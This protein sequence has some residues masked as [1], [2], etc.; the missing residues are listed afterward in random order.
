MNRLTIF[1]FCA[2][3]VVAVASHGQDEEELEEEEGHHHPANVAPVPV[4]TKPLGHLGDTV[5]SIHRAPI[6]TFI[7]GPFGP[8]NWYKK[9]PKCGQ[10]LQSPV[11]I[12][13]SKVIQSHLKPLYFHNTNAPL[14]N[15]IV[16]NLFRFGYVDTCDIQP[17]ATIS[18][19]P[20]PGKTQYYFHGLYFVVGKNRTHGSV[21][22]IVNKRAPFEIGFVFHANQHANLVNHDNGSEV[23]LHFMGKIVPEDNPNFLPITNALKQV[24]KGGQEARANLVSLQSLF[25]PK[26]TFEKKYYTYTGSSFIPPH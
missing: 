9:Y 18:G 7:Q 19:G 11:N 23:I 22:S 14:A 4:A 6:W 26:G 16:K 15:V 25:P 24:T 2:A 17:Q 3:L 5:L 12:E 1:F 20:L 21:S 13:H 10:Q 8:K